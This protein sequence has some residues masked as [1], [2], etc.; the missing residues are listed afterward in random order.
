MIETLEK[1]L[2]MVIQSRSVSELVAEFILGLAFVCSMEDSGLA[3]PTETRQL[4]IPKA[5]IVPLMSLAQSS[6]V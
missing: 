5:R 3:K 1:S 4:E 6:F 2:E